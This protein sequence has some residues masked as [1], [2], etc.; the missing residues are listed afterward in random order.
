MPEG[1]EVAVVAD[2]LHYLTGKYLV[3]LFCRQDKLIKEK[4][5]LSF[6]V[7]IER[8]YSR[9]KKIIFETPSFL[10]VTSLGMTGRYTYEETLHSHIRLIFSD[11]K[12][13]FTLYYDDVRRF[14]GIC[15]CD[16]SYLDIGPDLLQAALKSPLDIRDFVN[17]Y[18]RFPKKQIAVAL[19][20]QK[21]ISGIGNYLKSE[22][23]YYASIY[24][25][26]TIDQITNDEWYRLWV[27]SHQLIVYSYNYGGLTISDYISPSGKKGLY[28][29]AVYGKEYDNYG[30]TIK[31]EDDK[32]RRITFW[33]PKYF[34]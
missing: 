9:G 7:L 23:L 32:S 2:E 17:R 33:V 29:P 6:P 28:P 11:G 14:G 16:E 3:N 34:N 31:R 22:I 27:I 20:D 4:I 21:I 15:I 19:L 12:Q 18:L 10:L 26:K 13:S 25:F 24:P 30:N 5:S 8:I 1:P